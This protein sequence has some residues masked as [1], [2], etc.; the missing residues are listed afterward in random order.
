MRVSRDFR[1]LIIEEEPR[2]CAR[3]MLSSRSL[4]KLSLVGTWERFGDIGVMTRFFV[5]QNRLLLL[6]FSKTIRGHRT[7]SS[8]QGI[9][10]R[11]VG[12]G[13]VELRPRP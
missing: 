11:S 1:Y 12:S 3:N 4:F 13:C 2:L 10:W 6:R 5:Q 8:I 9:T 7:A